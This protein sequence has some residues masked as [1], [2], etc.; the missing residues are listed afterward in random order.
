MAVEPIYQSAL[1]PVTGSCRSRATAAGREPSPEALPTWPAAAFGVS[2]P[3]DRTSLSAGRFYFELTVQ[4][5]PAVLLNNTFYSLLH[6]A[7]NPLVGYH[8]CVSQASD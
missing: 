7:C 6:L 5:T 4:A 3:S 2:M 8:P 1:R